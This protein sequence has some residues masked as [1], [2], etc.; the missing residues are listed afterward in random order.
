MKQLLVVDDEPRIVRILKELFDEAGHQVR[1]A[2]DV[3]GAKKVIDGTAIDLIVSDIRLPDGNGIDVLKHALAHQPGV[4]VILITAYG[5]VQ[6]AVHAMRLGAYDFVQKPFDLE[7]L[8]LQ[9]ERAL[10]ATRTEEDLLVLREERRRKRRTLVGQSLAMRRVKELVAAVAPNPTT[11]LI[12]GESGTGKELVAEAIHDASRARDRPLVRINCLAIPGE[13]LE[14]ELFGHDRG[15]FTGADKSRKGWFE[16]ASGGTLFLDEIAD[17]PQSFQGKLL[18]TLEE[19]RITRV[20]GRTEIP[21]E[22]RLVA[23]SNVDLEERVREG[24]FREDLFYRLNVFP[25]HIP[26]LRE[27]VEDIPALAESLLSDLSI[28]FGRPQVKISRIAAEVLAGH[29]WPGNVRELRNV[30]ERALVIAH[31]E[32]IDLGHLPEE[33]VATPPAVAGEPAPRSTEGSLVE[34]V[35]EFKKRCLVEALQGS[36]WVKSNAARSLGLSPRALSH[37]VAR[38]DLDRYRS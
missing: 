18:R 31:G 5:S 24:R 34:R 17:V 6:D 20:G 37:Y 16:V 27:R 38:Y 22:T 26:P 35:E 32:T 28:R 4:Q 10:A 19:Q 11:V 23:A 2:E 29:S 30:L 12:G 21:I 15:A 1:T 7:A 13:L 33:I 14:S 9:V 3:A 25:I 8:S 36:Q